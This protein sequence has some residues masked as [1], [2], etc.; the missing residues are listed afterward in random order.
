MNQQSRQNQRRFP[1]RA[2]FIIAGV[3][4]VL[5]GVAF[6]IVAPGKVRLV[7]GKVRPEEEEIK[8]DIDVCDICCYARN[9][10]EEICNQRDSDQRIHGQPAQTNPWH[11]S[12]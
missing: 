8:T 11:V 1:R 3:L 4:C 2:A 5:A 7:P 10:K 6:W 9:Q 12:T